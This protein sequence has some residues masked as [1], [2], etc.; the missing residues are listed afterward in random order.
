M[1]N[2]HLRQTA[3]FWIDYV[4]E[5]SLAGSELPAIPKYLSLTSQ[6]S[7]NITLFTMRYAPELNAYIQRQQVL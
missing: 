7:N 2:L 6:S 1:N 4:V 5:S 3:E